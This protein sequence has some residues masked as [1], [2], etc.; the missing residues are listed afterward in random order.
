[1]YCIICGEDSELPVCENCLDTKQKNT[2]LI[3]LGLASEIKEVINDLS[4]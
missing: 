4:T 2:L 1:M 3:M